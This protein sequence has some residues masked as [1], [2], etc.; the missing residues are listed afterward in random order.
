MGLFAPAGTRRV[1][2]YLRTLL[3]L[4][5]WDDSG[6]LLLGFAV[7]RLGWRASHPEMNYEQWW[8]VHFPPMPPLMS[9]LVHPK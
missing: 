3:H 7:G 1:G 8:A 2:V 9:Y 5:N 4:P 6:P